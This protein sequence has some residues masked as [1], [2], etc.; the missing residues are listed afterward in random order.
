MP[1]DPIV[2][3][4]LAQM[5]GRPP[6]SSL[7][8]QQARALPTMMGTVY[9]A[10]PPLHEV[11]DQVVATAGGS[12]AVRVYLPTSAPRG[13]ATFLHG[14]GWVIGSIAGYDNFLRAMAHETGFAIV[15]ADYRMAPEHRFPAAVDDAVAVALWTQAQAASLV[16]PF[17]LMGDSA[18][19]NLAAAVA[20]LFAEQGIEVALQLLIYPVTDADFDRPSY[21]ENA[22]GFML[23]RDS[24]MWFWDQYAPVVA[25]RHDPR[26]AP[27]RAGSLAGRAPAFVLTAEYDPLRDEGEAYAVALQRAGVPAVLRRYDGMIHG[28]VA[29]RAL[30][31]A[32]ANAHRDMVAAFDAAARGIPLASA[33]GAAA[34]QE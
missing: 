8:P 10:G 32:A 18:G 29:L 34:R 3:N 2:E 4:L 14:G 16:L 5:A 26:A 15:S 17:V 21:R 22:E 12:V 27:L 24:M 9:P 19:A 30:C 20:G 6:M 33:L 23:T 13:Y 28:F 1:L 31:P 25:D 7:T 11:S